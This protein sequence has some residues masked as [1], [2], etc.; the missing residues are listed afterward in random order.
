MQTR[1]TFF[2]LKFNT[3]CSLSL[4]YRAAEYYGDDT[5]RNESDNKLFPRNNANS[6][7]YE[8]PAA[9][10]PESPKAETCDGHY[11]YPSSAAGYS[12]E[13]AQQLNSAFSQPQTSSHMQ[14]LAPFPNE[15]V[16]YFS[17]FCSG[18]KMVSY[19][20]LGIHYLLLVMRNTSQMLDP[21]VSYIPLGFI[22]F[23]VCSSFLHYIDSLVSLAPLLWGNIST[24]LHSV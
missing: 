22:V 21:P 2:D 15:A 16:R 17:V 8:L 18:Y 24:V 14:N 19:A 6:G 5:L 7:N 12:Y 3:Q 13:S 4:F 23:W 9:S 10:Q 11:S 1:C 20:L